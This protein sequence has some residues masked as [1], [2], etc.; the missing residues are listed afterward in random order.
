MAGPNSHDS[1]RGLKH[2]VVQEK[3]ICL[4]YIDNATFSVFIQVNQN[5]I[6]VNVTEPDL[7]AFPEETP[8]PVLP[9]P[10]VCRKTLVKE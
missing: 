3:G 7:G 10:F 8:A 9:L 2:F 5:H 4:L 6:Y 1:Q